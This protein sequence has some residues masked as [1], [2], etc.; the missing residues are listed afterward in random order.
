LSEVA[1]DWQSLGEMFQVERLLRG[2]FRLAQQTCID[3]GLVRVMQNLRSFSINT[4]FK[5]SY[6]G[7]DFAICRGPN[8][9]RA[10]K[11]NRRRVVGE[12]TFVKFEEVVVIRRLG[13]YFPDD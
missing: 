1:S 3:F 10:A 4:D 2:D 7:V 11:V 5:I 8:W 6:S 13:P 12:F 9:C